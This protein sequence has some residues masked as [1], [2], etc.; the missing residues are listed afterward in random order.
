MN[1][2][3]KIILFFLCLSFCVFG[4]ADSTNSPLLELGNKN[5]FQLEKINQSGYTS[6]ASLIELDAQALAIKEALPAE[7]QSDV[8][9]YFFAISP[10][11]NSMKKADNGKNTIVFLNYLE[12]IK[13]KSKYYILMGTTINR[14]GKREFEVE[15]NLPPLQIEPPIIV[16]KGANFKEEP[17]ANKNP[18][19]SNEF[20]KTVYQSGA[21]DEEKNSGSSN[22]TGDPESKA[23]KKIVSTIGGSDV[24]YY[25]LNP[26]GYVIFLDKATLNI[27][28]KYLD[29]KYPYTISGWDTNDGKKFSAVIENDKFKGYREVGSNETPEN[30]LPPNNLKITDDIEL[31]TP[32][33]SC[34]DDKI[35]YFWYYGK[36]KVGNNRTDADYINGAVKVYENQV[37]SLAN[38]KSCSSSVPQL[39]DDCKKNNFHTHDIPDN[40]RNQVG[41]EIMT[42]IKYENWKNWL[43]PLQGK[44][45]VSKPIIFVSTN[46]STA[47]FQAMANIK[48]NEKEVL[49]WYIYNPDLYKDRFI[50]HKLRTV[51]TFENPAERKSFIFSA[52]QISFTVVYAVADLLSQAAD[53]VKIPESVYDCSNPSSYSSIYAD[54]LKK[55]LPENAKQ[56]YE[57]AY[58]IGALPNPQEE[59]AFYCGFYN[60]IIGTAQS[61]PDLVKLFSNVGLAVADP[62]KTL[63][64]IKDKW[65]TFN[66]PVYNDETQTSIKCDP[67]NPLNFYPCKI[68]IY[69]DMVYNAIAKKYANKPCLQSELEG[70]V[71]GP[72]LALYVG[73]YLALANVG[74]LGN[75]ISPFFKFLSWCDKIEDAFAPG[76][77]VLKYIFKNNQ[78]TYVVVDKSKKVVA[79][80]LDNGKYIINTFYDKNRNPISIPISGIEIDEIQFKKALEGDEIEIETAPNVKKKGYLLPDLSINIAKFK[81]YIVGNPKMI[82]VGNSYNFDH[83]GT[84]IEVAVDEPNGIVKF[85]D[86]IDENNP[87]TKVVDAINDNDGIICDG[88]NCEVNFG[89]GCFIAG[90]KVHTR[91]GIKKIE[92]IK[93]NEEVLAFDENKKSTTF[94][95][96]ALAFHL[97]AQNLTKVIIGKDTL[98]TTPNHPFYVPSATNEANGTHWIDAGRLR[99]GVLVLLASGVLSSV[100]TI[101]TYAANTPVY[102]FSVE[103][104]NNYYV[105]NEGILVH[106]TILCHIEALKDNLKA[107]KNADGTQKYPDATINALAN[108][109]KNL[110]NSVNLTKRFRDREI[111]VEAWQTIKKHNQVVGQSEDLMAS[112]TARAKKDN[113]FALYKDLENADL[114]EAYRQM[115]NSPKDVWDVYNHLKEMFGNKTPPQD[116]PKPL[117]NYAQSKHWRNNGE[118]GRAFQDAMKAPIRNSNAIRLKIIAELK[119][120]GKVAS[121][122]TI[123]DLDK[124]DV[125]ENLRI[126]TIVEG[127]K[128]Y[129]EIDFALVKQKQGTDEWDVFLVDAKLSGSAPATPH[130]NALLGEF[131]GGKSKGFKTW[132]TNN[133]SFL[134]IGNGKTINIKAAVRLNGPQGNETVTKFVNE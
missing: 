17:T 92:D 109:I 79:R 132:N 29:K 15:I 122:F 42:F 43:N 63:N 134:D 104:Y 65:K 126:E 58:N 81:K 105:G 86:N 31:W 89:N 96:V 91:T 56:M 8:K 88:G 125:V 50:L 9:I 33:Y 51:T 53:K 61:I 13:T 16:E 80:L 127:K 130:Q 112:I 118:L 21:D 30:Y 107:L 37:A 40:I 113:D 70:E 108:D 49:L 35:T 38:F 68:G 117:L 133:S 19:S 48:L 27:S 62:A 101:Y 60:G 45:V 1:L 12:T 123:P 131:Y 87:T 39:S 110:P 23:A 84:T 120:Q 114:F 116:I 73:D 94:A 82:H 75:T 47:A 85:K 18:N 64:T 111:S 69:K 106:N 52:S 6:T 11:L 93:E 115:R 41:A 3:N 129:T 28:Q 44:N 25:H 100:D 67:S 26:S 98:T 5:P 95:R 34:E 76:N 24:K 14:Q 59:F 74:E 90:T 55:V 103:N 72:M 7:Y 102:N 119:A 124:Y 32:S 57:V 97:T 71:I 78:M 22:N 99:K 77:L 2:K 121:N 66:E 54:A 4:Q 46:E 20:L 83:N 128:V 36:Y 10:T